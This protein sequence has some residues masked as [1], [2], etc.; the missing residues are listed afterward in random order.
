[1]TLIASFWS[2]LTVLSQTTAPSLNLLEALEISLFAIALVFFTLVIIMALV[3]IMS[4][5]LSIFK[6]PKVG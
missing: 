3:K 1:M 2:F 4:S 6:E 5:V